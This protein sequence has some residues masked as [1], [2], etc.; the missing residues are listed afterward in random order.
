MSVRYVGFFDEIPDATFT[1]SVARESIHDWLGESVS[2]PRDR[3][4]RY[5][6]SGHPVVERMSSAPDVLDETIT[7]R[8]GESTLTDGEWV[9]RW[10]LT[11]YVDRYPLR[12]PEEFLR[13]M[14]RNDYTPP[15]LKDEERERIVSQV[16]RD[17]GYRRS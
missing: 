17:L 13:T 4:L 2:Y 1:D 16:A 5:L 14:E 10:D 8:G 7:I 9:W 11:H 3:V 12:L 15:P 6:D